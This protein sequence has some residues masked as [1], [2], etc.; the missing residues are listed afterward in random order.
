MSRHNNDANR[1][2]SV[3]EFYPY[4]LR[5][6]QHPICRLLH[7]IGS[8]SALLALIAIVWGQFWAWLPLV[9]LI[10][11]GFAWIGHF[12]FEHNRPATFQYPRLSFIGDWLMLKDFLTGQID[13]KLQQANL[14][15][16]PIQEKRH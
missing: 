1:L 12:F 14:L 3:D 2:M 13:Q 6:H 4:Y 7:Y 8:A 9:L 10:G 11:Y 15:T 16:Q 5:E